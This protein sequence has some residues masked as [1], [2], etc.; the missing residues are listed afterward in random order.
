[1][2]T[3]RRTNIHTGPLTA[4]NRPTGATTRIGTHTHI[5]RTWTQIQIEGVHAHTHGFTGA[6]SPFAFA[7]DREHNHREREYTSSPIRTNWAPFSSRA[8]TQQKN[9]ERS[10]FYVKKTHTRSGDIPC[11]SSAHLFSKVATA[12]LRTLQDVAWLRCPWTGVCRPAGEEWQRSSNSSSSRSSRSLSSPSSSSSSTINISRTA[13]S[14][15]FKEKLCTPISI[16][17]TRPAIS[18]APVPV[19]PAVRPHPQPGA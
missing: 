6:R 4:T 11:Q 17:R 10:P 19:V 7:I 9:D 15:D 1:M 13:I 8:D 16:A 3:F 18:I 12:L 2:W 14:F 5:Q